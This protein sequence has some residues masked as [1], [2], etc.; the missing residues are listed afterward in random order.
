ME[1]ACAKV[2]EN[3]LVDAGDWIEKKITEIKA[4]I[5]VAHK[6]E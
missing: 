1:K 3:D 2:L 4:Q 6:T 5:Q